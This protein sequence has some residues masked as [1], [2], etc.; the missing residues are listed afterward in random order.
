MKYKDYLTEIQSPKSYSFDMIKNNDG[1][2]FDMTTGE[3][4]DYRLWL[5]K[6][7][8][9]YIVELG[10]KSDKKR[11]IIGDFYDVN[12]LIATMADIFTKIHLELERLNHI[13]YKFSPTD[14]KS[15]I[16]LMIS[17]FRDELKNYYEIPNE[18]NDLSNINDVDRLII[19]TTNGQGL[20]VDD[21]KLKKL[22]SV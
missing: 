6:K 21:N 5:S 16:L 18:L 10:Y 17:I 15:Y 19:Q 12:V 4:F 11:N 13:V 22:K 3:E 14:D 1:Y 2:V 7:D 9:F 8:D 20:F